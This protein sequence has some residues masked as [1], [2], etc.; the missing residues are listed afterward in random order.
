MLQFDARLYAAAAICMSKEEKRYYLCGVF[1]EPHAVKGVTLTTTDGVRLICIHDES[2]SAD[3]SAIIALSADAL[4]ACKAK[5]S[6]QAQLCG[7]VRV[8]TVD[9]ADAI[10]SEIATDN[11]TG[12]K[13]EIGKVAISQKCRVDGTFP[14][15]RRVVPRDLLGAR[16]TT[17]GA[18]K[19]ADPG[20]FDAR[21]LSSLCDVAEMLSDARE[22]AVRVVCADASSP[23][24]I[25][26][27]GAPYAFGVLMPVK[28]AEGCDVPAWLNAR[29]ETAE[30]AA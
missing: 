30:Q 1:V 9:G 12:E 6:R 28:G 16:N 3:E 17:L 7:A 26:F 23:A 10:V 24:L 11:S 22:S 25:L 14:D 27:S 5:V 8:V 18:G 19:N 2:G 4:K 20:H 15:Y 21:Q 13:T 29:N